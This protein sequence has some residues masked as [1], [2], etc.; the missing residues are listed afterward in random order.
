[1]AFSVNKKI[2]VNILT[3]ICVF[4][5]AHLINEYRKLPASKYYTYKVEWVDLQDKY[6]TETIKAKGEFSDFQIGTAA[7]AMQIM[8]TGDTVLIEGGKVLLEI[9]KAK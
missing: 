6:V 8:F 5:C 4:A 9:E 7:R 3:L 1:M 2:V